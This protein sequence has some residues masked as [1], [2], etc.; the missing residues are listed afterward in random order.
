MAVLAIL[1]SH[2]HP[3]TG[4]IQSYTEDFTTKT[5]CDTLSTTAWWDTAAGELKLHALTP[6]LVGTYDTPG[7]AFAVTISGDQAFIAD[8]TG[9]LHIID[10]TDPADPVL[11]GTHGTPHKAADVAVAS[12][13]AFVADGLSGLQIVDVTDPVSPAFVGAYDTP[14]LALGVA[15]DGTHAFVADGETGLIVIDCSDPS[16]P[17]P[18]GLQ[19]TSGFA[20]D[21]EVSGDLAFLADDVAGLVVFDISDLT[22]PAIISTYDTPGAARGVA[23]AGDLAFVSDESSGLHI[24]DVSDPASPLHVS[25]TGTPGDAIGI[26]V[27]G[28]L[29]FVACDTQGLQVFD[30]RDPS[31]PVIANAFVTPSSAIGVAVAG[32]LA[33]VTDEIQG[34]HVIRVRYPTS[35]ALEGTFVDSDGIYDVA[36]SGDLAFVAAQT[37]LLIIDISDPST[38]VVIGSYDTPA[39]TAHIAIA[40]NLAFL[41]EYDY[42]NYRYTLL[43]VDVTDPAS[44]A[45][46]SSHDTTDSIN[47]L[48]VADDL[49]L[50]QVAFSGLEIYD[51][52]DPTSPVLVGTSGGPF[53]GSTIYGH[54]AYFGGSGLGILDISDPSMPVPVGSCSLFGNGGFGVEVEGDLAYLANGIWGLAVVDISDPT[55]PEVLSYTWTEEDASHIAVSGN[56]A[57]VTDRNWGLHVFDITDPVNPVLTDVYDTPDDAR[58][59][60]IEG[61]LAFIADWAGGLHIL[62]IYQHELDTANHAGQSLPVDGASSTIPRARVLD[63]ST[64]VVSWELSADAGASWTA[65]ATPDAWTRIASPGADLQWRS[66]LELGGVGLPTVSE[67]TL[68]WL[69]ESGPVVSITDIADDQG[70]WVRLS[71]G[72]SGYD[73]ADESS[74]PVATYQIY[75]RLDDEVLRRQV[76]EDGRMADAEVLERAPMS[77]LHP[78]AVRS[79]RDRLYVLGEEGSARGEMPPGV[80]EILT[81]VSALQQDEYVV[82]VPTLGDSSDAGIA[83]SVN[84]VTTHTTTPSIWFASAPDSGYSVDNI[85]PGIP[86]GLALLGTELSWDAAP[87]DDFRHHSVYGSELEEFDPAAT[88]MGY[89]VDPIYDVSGASYGYYHVT[90][91]DHVGNE[92]DAASVEGS[93]LSSPEAPIPMTY[94]LSSPGP[95]PSGGRTAMTFALPEAGNVQLA[96]YDASGRAVRTLADGAYAPAVHRVFWDARDDCGRR[97]GPGVY[98]VRIEVGTFHAERRLTVMR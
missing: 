46:V 53:G 31:N 10:V 36:V 24:I 23:V 63:V 41:A 65:V 69:N 14:D 2:A 75:R 19:D 40:G 52:S 3:A 30:I 55:A 11:L 43:I 82:A 94:T 76:L 17:V 80:W 61:E 15:V 93:L 77:S 45:L 72:R 67:L 1:V 74:L 98:F 84:L 25:T 13:R 35:P 58:R 87:E 6:T 54:R 38:P 62:R 28:D 71:F 88:L 95:N 8:Y 33:F 47:S 29:V 5:Y 26:T 16:N 64:G 7:S 48:S 78:S 81:T 21:V 42:S 50:V 39:T 91:T 59:V 83:W 32:D 68:E 56:I 9:G 86:S 92:G 44:P 20:W 57:L 70:G 90:T 37:G 79:F 73:F 27:S 34:L 51:V 60:V 12:D 85:A 4:V 18:V 22:N 97:V 66:L 49:L 96:I 89:T